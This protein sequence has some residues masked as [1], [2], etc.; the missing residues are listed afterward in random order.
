MLTRT[1]ANL[2]ARENRFRLKTI[3]SVPAVII[4]TYADERGSRNAI[5]ALAG[6]NREVDLRNP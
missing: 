2:V 4:R 5:E 3:K 1:I 6:L